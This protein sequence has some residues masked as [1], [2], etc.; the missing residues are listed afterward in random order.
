MNGRYLRELS[1]DELTARL[2][3][4]T[5]R[6]GLRAAVEISADKISTLDEFWP[7]AGFIF[8]GPADDPASYEKWIAADGG[9]AAHARPVTRWPTWRTGTSRRS[10]P[11]CAGPS[12]ARAE[13]EAIFQPIRVALAGKPVS[14]G[15]FETLAVLGRDESLRRIDAAIAGRRG[16]SAGPAP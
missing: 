6:S 14:P 2:E 4:L 9:G 10:R 11:P 7:L 5:G 1:V 12:S 15:I 13:A 8:D 16:R 3:Q